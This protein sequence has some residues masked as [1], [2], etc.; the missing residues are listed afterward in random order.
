M[1]VQDYMMYYQKVSEVGIRE[2]L[3]V[4]VNEYGIRLIP[5]TCINIGE[6]IL[7][8]MFSWGIKTILETLQ[9]TSIYSNSI[10][11]YLIIY[12][13]MESIQLIDYNYESNLYH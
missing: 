11:T 8:K 4:W 12:K 2:F 5:D 10:I 9:Y 13:R 7:L 6:S 1:T 3:P